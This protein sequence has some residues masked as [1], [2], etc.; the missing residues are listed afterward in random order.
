[1]VETAA[2]RLGTNPER[3]KVNPEQKKIEPTRNTSRIGPCVLQVEKTQAEE[4]RSFSLF[5]GGADGR[6]RIQLSP[7]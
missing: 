7:A 3:K 6:G 5:L 1:M 2:A 4:F